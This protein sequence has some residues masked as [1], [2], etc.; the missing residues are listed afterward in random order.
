MK[1]SLSMLKYNTA[2]PA[3]QDLKKKAKQ[4]IPKFAFDYLEGGCNEDVNLARNKSELQ[5]VI[6][7]PQYLKKFKGLNMGV[8]LFG[9]QYDAPFGISPI[10]LQGLIWPDSPEILAKAALK[11]NIPY[12]LSTVSTSS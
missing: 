12:I 2:Y 4:R 6:L 11:Q 7:K 5:D 1:E 3:I 9:H 10:G 8:N